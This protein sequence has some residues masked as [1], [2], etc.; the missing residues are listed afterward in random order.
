MV[1]VK[2]E[3]NGNGLGGIV[4]WANGNLEI[5]NCVN[6][7]TLLNSNCATGGIIGVGEDMTGGIYNSY[8]AGEIHVKGPSSSGIVGSTN[9]NIE[10]INVYNKGDI[11]ENGNFGRGGI[12]GSNYTVVGSG[13][14]YITNAYN[15]GNVIENNLNWS[16]AAG[17]IC[18]YPSDTSTLTIENSYYKKGTCSVAVGLR[19]DSLYGVSS[20]NEINYEEMIKNFKEFIDDNKSKTSEWKYW[21]LGEDGYPTLDYNS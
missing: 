5:I 1:D 4:G 2:L 12:L 19:K 16:Y 21:I 8:N 13:N 18:G 7:N 10:I 17:A 11:T 9:S 3:G 6:L 14:V 20:L 15:L